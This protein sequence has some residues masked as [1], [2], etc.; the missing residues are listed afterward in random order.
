MICVI[1]G[2]MTSDL[3]IARW[4]QALQACRRLGGDA[5]DMK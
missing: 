3:W 4:E 5:R 1:G 2:F